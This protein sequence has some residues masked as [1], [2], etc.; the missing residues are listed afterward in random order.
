MINA[1][2]KLRGK[3]FI[4]ARCRVPELIQ[5]HDRQSKTSLGQLLP[6]KSLCW[7]KAATG[8]KILSQ[9]LSFILKI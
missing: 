6:M 5:I 9:T 2:E 1:L 4:K 3:H 7:V 8:R